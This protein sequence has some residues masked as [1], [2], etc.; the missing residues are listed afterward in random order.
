[1]QAILSVLAWLKSGSGA[2][3]FAVLY[4]MCEA[5]AAIPQVESNSVFQLVSN[6]IKSIKNLLGGSNPPA[7]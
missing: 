1:M 6:G 3:L 5:L 7:S 2:V 4:G